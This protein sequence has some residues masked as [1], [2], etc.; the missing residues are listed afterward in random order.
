[1]AKEPAMGVLVPI[2]VI[3]ICVLVLVVI[4]WLIVKEFLYPSMLPKPRKIQPPKT[5]EQIEEDKRFWEEMD[6]EEERRRDRSADCA[7]HPQ[8]AW[9]GEPFVLRP[10]VPAP[11][12]RSSPVFAAEKPKRA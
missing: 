9:K 8:R 1:M 2:I 3:C 12:S 6:R 11:G 10:R 4:G 7:A 5:P